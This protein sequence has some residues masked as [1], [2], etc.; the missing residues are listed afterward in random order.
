MKL[1][2]VV[3]MTIMVMFCY[4]Y[5]VA[6]PEHTH[7][8]YI[9]HMDKSDMPSTFSDHFKWYQMSMRLVSKFSNML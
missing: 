6:D 5:V 2:N 4:H 8:T 9:V 7:I 3:P 1:R